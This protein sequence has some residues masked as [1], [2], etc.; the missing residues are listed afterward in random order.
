MTELIWGDVISLPLDWV[1]GPGRLPIFGGD[2]A[3]YALWFWL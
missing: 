2:M 3:A 1:V